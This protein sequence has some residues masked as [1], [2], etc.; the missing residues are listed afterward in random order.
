MLS[1]LASPLLELSTGFLPA[2]RFA[3]GA[4]GVGFDA[5]GRPADP[6]IPLAAAAAGIG[7][8]LRRIHSGVPMPRRRAALQNVGH[9]HG[10]G[11]GGSAALDVTNSAADE[12]AHRAS[13]NSPC[14][15]N[16]GGRR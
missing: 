13:G 8:P 9:T 16:T 15:T 12:V 6:F 11:G 10:L 3:G 7:A 1:R 4:G 2:G 14:S 5:A